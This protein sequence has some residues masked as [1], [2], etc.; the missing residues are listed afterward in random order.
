[1]NVQMVPAMMPLQAAASRRPGAPSEVDPGDR[2]NIG[3]KA[4]GSVGAMYGARAGRAALVAGASAAAGTVASSLGLGGW[5]VGVA[6]VLGLAGG[7]FLEYRTGAGRF[8]GA[9]AGGALGAGV[10]KLAETAGWKPSEK[11]QQVT[12]NFSLSELPSHLRS[13]THT[14]NPQLR[15]N[16]EAVEALKNAQPGD[17][18]MVQDE[19]LFAGATTY[20]R[21]GGASG[22]YTH[23]GV[24]SDTGTLIDVMQNDWK[25]K[26]LD[27]WLHCT[28]MAIIRPR[29]ENTA[30]AWRVVD[31]LREDRKTVRF[32]PG[33]DLKT[34]DLQYCGEFALKG[35]RKYA[36]EI[37]VETSSRLGYE[38]VTAD[39][40]LASPDVDVIYDSGSKHWYNQVS[41]F[42]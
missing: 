12:R 1:M 21:L 25:E 35:L 19:N 32:D 2:V 38:F 3:F 22:D 39:N 27:F 24:V 14:S 4:G 23:L 16:P 28:N 41:R 11:L 29:Y 6:A 31:G 9:M 37:K 5:G 10:G 34:D 18:L 8:A 36:P 26:P 20:Q 13:R 7:A 40:F 30:S 17:I 15:Y 42:A 33:F